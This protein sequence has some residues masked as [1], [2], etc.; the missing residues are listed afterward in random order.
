MACAVVHGNPPFGALQ[1][2]QQ[3]GFTQWASERA[4]GGH[5]GGPSASE[6]T[7]GGAGGAGRRGPLSRRRCCG[8][9]PLGALTGRCAL[10][11][12][13]YRIA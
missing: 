9:L 6:V 2:V 5:G 3:Q 7:G 1:N 10:P 11:L 13:S 8:R 4:T 12:Y